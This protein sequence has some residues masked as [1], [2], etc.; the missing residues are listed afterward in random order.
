MSK[1]TIINHR[2][3]CSF[4]DLEKKS[5]MGLIKY[6]MPERNLDNIIS[7]LEFRTMLL[8]LELKVTE[9]YDVLAQKA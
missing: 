7:I 1:K 9:S 4:N 2:L 3:Y 6:L 5:I 8:I